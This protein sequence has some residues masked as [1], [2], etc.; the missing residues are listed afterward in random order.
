M[1]PSRKVAGRQPEKSETLKRLIAGGAFIAPIVA[2]FAVQ[3]C[4]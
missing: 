4:R 2:A 3:A 1:N